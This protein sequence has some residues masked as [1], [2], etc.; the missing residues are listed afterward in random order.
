MAYGV[1]M[2]R[3]TKSTWGGK[4]KGSGRKHTGRKPYCFRVRPD[5]VKEVI[6]HY[7]KLGAFIESLAEKI[8]A[9]S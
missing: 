8:R 9:S 6:A 3:K 1:G 2:K 5:A 7:G 4:R